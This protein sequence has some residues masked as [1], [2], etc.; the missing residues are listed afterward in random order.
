MAGSRQQATRY[1]FAGTQAHDEEEV[2]TK[3]CPRCGE[4]LFADMDVCFGCLYDFARD[5]EGRARGGGHAQHTPQRLAR[6][7]SGVIAGPDPLEGVELDEIDDEIELPSAETTQEGPPVLPRHSKLRASSADSTLD[8]SS[9]EEPGPQPP[10]R[11]DF[12]IVVRSAEMQLRV[13]LPAQ[14]LSIGRG[15]GNDVILS[16]RSVSRQHIRLMPLVDAVLVEDCGATN[17]ATINEVALE[18]TAQLAPG[19]AVVV[20]G[21][22]FE[23]EAA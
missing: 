4:L 19:Q 2:Q 6:D 5:S 1:V 7:A 23:V 12:C 13:P 3:T 16:S 15:E 11:G 14:G 20:C 17:P 9:L 21:T 8:L 22:E 18:G 10:A